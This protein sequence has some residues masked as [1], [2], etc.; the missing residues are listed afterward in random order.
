[1]TVDDAREPVCFVLILLY[2]YIQRLTRYKI[3]V[4]IFCLSACYFLF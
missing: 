4:D 3:N 2:F 1:M